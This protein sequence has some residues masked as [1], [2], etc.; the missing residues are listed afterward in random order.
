MMTSSAIKVRGRSLV[1]GTVGILCV[2]LLWE[3]LARS[4]SM[5]RGLFPPPTTVF[6]ELWRRTLSGQVPTDVFTSLQRAAVGF[7][8]G[9]GLGLCL[10]VL[11][12]RLGAAAAALSP[13]LNTLRSIPSISLVPLAIVWFGLGERSKYF[14]VA[15][16]TLFPVWVNTHLGIRNVPRVL[17]WAARSLGARE[18]GLTMKVLIPA[19]LPSIVNGLR[20]SVAIAY[21]ALVASEMAGSTAGLGYRIQLSY[22]VLRV[23]VMLANL[24]VLGVLGSLS[25]RLLAHWI[26][27]RFPWIQR[28][29]ESADHERI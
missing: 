18:P 25:D 7:G 5:P 15:W 17:V 14:L 12:G 27:R 19:A 6:V 4:S 13:L 9:G 16:A 23:D 21:L 29:N 28:M 3:G 1:I 22:Q 20:V 24:V 8:L 11:T 2:V 26:H 10:G